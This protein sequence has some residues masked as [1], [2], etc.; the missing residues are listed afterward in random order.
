MLFFGLVSKKERWGLTLWGWLFVCCLVIVTLAAA[1]FGVHPFLAVNEPVG[2]EILVMEGWMPDELVEKVIEI[3]KSEH[4]QR[5]VTTGGPL[6]YGSY[7]VGY[8]NCAE[9][10]AASL[11]KLGLDERL[12]FVMPA[13]DVPTDN[14]YAAGV[15]LRDWLTKSGTAVRSLDI[16]TMGPHARRTRLLF[17]KA[18]GDDVKVGVFALESREYDPEIWWRTSKGVRTVL[19]EAVAYVYARF[20][21]WPNSLSGERRAVSA[22]R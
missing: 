12:I 20:F 18:L 17:E 9:V 13:P 21:F 14:T 7:L 16:C 6:T 15:S 10:A 2:G 3:F 8:K 4:Y 1:V 19:K 5:L 11:K 22:E